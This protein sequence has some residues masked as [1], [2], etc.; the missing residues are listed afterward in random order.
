MNECAEFLVKYDK[1]VTLGVRKTG[2]QLNFVTFKLCDFREV[3]ESC[4]ISI[5]F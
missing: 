4:F 2:Y 5:S 1:I 3:I